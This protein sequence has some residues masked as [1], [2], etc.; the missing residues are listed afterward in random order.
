MVRPTNSYE[1]WMYGSERDT[2]LPLTTNPLPPRPD[3]E[4]K[5][6][7]WSSQGR[8]RLYHPECLPPNSDPSSMQVQPIFVRS[9]IPDGMRN[10]CSKCGE[11]IFTRNPTT[12]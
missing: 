3:Q 11:S 5:G 1:Y 10:R 7:I 6:Y 2:L 4:R 8:P 9:D 12:T